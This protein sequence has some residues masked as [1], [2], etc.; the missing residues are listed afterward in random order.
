MTLI[1]VALLVCQVALVAAFLL[2][3]DRRERE[4]RMERLGL[5]QRIQAPELAVMQ[6]QI[7]QNPESPPAVS[8]DNDEDYWAAMEARMEQTY[9]E[10]QG[11]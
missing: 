4:H 7:E 6:H 11:Q 10:V 8:T 1:V 5:Y 2:A 3:W 9:L